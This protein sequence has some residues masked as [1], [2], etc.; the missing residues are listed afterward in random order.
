MKI[1]KV[2]QLDVYY[3]DEKYYICLGMHEKS[4]Y[5]SF[6]FIEGE[7]NQAHDF[8]NR[9]Y[10]NDFAFS[11]FAECGY[12][13]YCGETFEDYIYYAMT[14]FITYYETD[15]L[16]F[17][18]PVSVKNLKM[19][20]LDYRAKKINVKKEIVK[21][22]YLKNR[23]LGLVNFYTIKDLMKLPCNQ[24]IIAEY[25][26]KKEDM[27]K[28]QKYYMK[29][30]FNDMLANTSVRLYKDD[31][32]LYY[33]YIHGKNTGRIYYHYKISMKEEP[34]VKVKHFFQVYNFGRASKNTRLLVDGL[35][36]VLSFDDLSN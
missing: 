29:A 20:E 25:A 11:G 26:W 17:S 18:K 16:D 33:V 4:S 10:K 35:E 32:Y 8:V 34:L 13:L 9:I 24:G 31:N 27:R 21:N 12:E 2:K 14:P 15:T 6:E 7:L 1:R 22:W 28:A 30:L 19:F 36:P 5:N 23:L 3:E